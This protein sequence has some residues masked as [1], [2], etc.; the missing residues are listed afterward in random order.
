MARFTIAALFTAL[1]VTGLTGLAMAEYPQPES[2]SSPVVAHLQLRDRTVTITSH[3]NGYLYSVADR[4]GAVLS[5]AMT[6]QEIA[7][8]YP[9]LFDLLQPAVAD[10]KDAE[11]MMLAPLV[12]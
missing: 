5:A 8:Q 1:S 9:E 2:H 3:P 10:D 11:L 12:Q 6:E 4:S 7:E